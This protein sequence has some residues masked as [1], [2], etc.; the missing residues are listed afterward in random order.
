MSQKTT[1]DLKLIFIPTSRENPVTGGEIYNLKLV[2]F[3]RE[4]FSNM[5]CIESSVLRRKANRSYQVLFF[6]LTSLIRN[7]LYYIKLFKIRRKTPGKRVIILEDIYYSTDLFLFNSLIR[8]LKKDI[9]IVPIV[10]HLYHPL[11]NRHLYSWLMRKVETL[12]LGQADLIITTSEATINSIREIVRQDKRF[13][14]AY[15]GLDKHRMRTRREDSLERKGA[16]LNLL[17]VGSVTR[18]KDIKTLVKAVKILAEQPAKV[19][20]SVDVV[21]DLEKERD[22]A[23]EVVKLVSDSSLSGHISFR[24]RVDDEELSRLYSRG[25]I[26][27]TTSLHEGFGMAI[28]E[29]MYN[30]LPV[31]AT[32]GGAIPYLVENGVTGFLVPPGDYKQLAEKINSLSGSERLRKEMG[33]RGFD[34]AKEF[35]WGKS[36]KKIYE[37]LLEA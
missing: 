13:L 26:F 18:R 2:E 21:G 3:L 4:K 17:V 12:F 23:T 20:F 7:I 5:E 29:A 6:G 19:G 27:I 24:G 16:K 8:R 28:A 10:H 36:F 33:A 15:P 30:R 9:V 31:V 32:S 14:V 35:D 22:Y 34:R 25:D 11:Q 37:G 1:D